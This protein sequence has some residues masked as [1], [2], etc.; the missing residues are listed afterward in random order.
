M[1]KKTLI[2][3]IMEKTGM[4]SDEIHKVID[5]L[6]ESIGESVQAGEDVSLMGLGTFYISERQSRNGYDPV[7]GIQ[8]VFPTKRRVKFRE[9]KNLK[10]K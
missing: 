5:C 3:K 1:N 9:S 2:R 6:I 8:T 4:K 7:R 10:L